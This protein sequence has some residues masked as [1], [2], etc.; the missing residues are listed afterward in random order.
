[1]S[2]TNTWSPT[3]SNLAVDMRGPA[4]EGVHQCG[5]PGPLQHGSVGGP[6]HSGLIQNYLI[7][8]AGSS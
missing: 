3:S 2:R 4:P 7:T 5:Q 1:M 6:Q 8:A